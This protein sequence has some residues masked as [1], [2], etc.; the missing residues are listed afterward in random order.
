M[1]CDK[2]DP[3]SDSDK[4][5]IYRVDTGSSRA[6]DKEQVYLSNPKYT[7][8]KQKLSYRNY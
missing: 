7:L 8:D 6:F 2:E 5:I 3:L 1:E 4:N